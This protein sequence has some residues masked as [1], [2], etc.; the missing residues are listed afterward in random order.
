MTYVFRAVFMVIYSKTIRSI[1]YEFTLINISIQV[2][3][4]PLAI[5]LVI[6]PFT[7]VFCSIFPGLLP[8]AV[9]DYFCLRIATNSVKYLHHLP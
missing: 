5:C 1:V 9:L 7:L 3:E 6:A 2:I 4:D 8:V